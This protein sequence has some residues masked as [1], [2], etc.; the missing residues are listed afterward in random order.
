MISPNYDRQLGR[1][2][3][4]PDSEQTPKP[5]IGQHRAHTHRQ[6]SRT[7]RAAHDRVKCSCARGSLITSLAHLTNISPRPLIIVFSLVTTCSIFVDEKA[8]LSR[9]ASRVVGAV[10]ADRGSL[11]ISSS[12]IAIGTKSRFSIGFVVCVFFYGQNSKFLYI[13]TSRRTEAHIP[14]LKL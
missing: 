7:T 2:F 10:I 14:I 5:H 4:Q 12:P 11:E 13:E 6:N 1:N 3:E 9:Q 8:F